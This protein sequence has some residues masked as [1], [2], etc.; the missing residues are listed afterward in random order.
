[1]THLH[2]SM[3]YL[4]LSSVWV[5][6][7]QVGGSPVKAGS[8]REMSRSTSSPV[9]SH[10]KSTSTTAWH[11]VDLVARQ[12]SSWIFLLISFTYSRVVRLLVSPLTS[13]PS[14]PLAPHSCPPLSLAIL[15]VHPLLISTSLNL[16][17]ALYH[18]LLVRLSCAL[19][20]RGQRQLDPVCET[21]LHW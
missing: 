21:V 16:P 5:G 14:V 8:N 18:G 17:Y 6:H 15:S 7:I 9:K 3:V 10:S 1:M 13:R 19:L 11:Q 2:R 20:V 12:V 4:L